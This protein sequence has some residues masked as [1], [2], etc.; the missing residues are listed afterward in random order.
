MGSETGPRHESIAGVPKRHDEVPRFFPSARQSI[1]PAAKFPNAG[2]LHLAF[3]EESAFW[4]VLVVP[5]TWWPR[6]E[7]WHSCDLF[8]RRNI[9]R[10]PLNIRMDPWAGPTVHHVDT[11]I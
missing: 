4:D 9:P 6:E 10:K 2:D 3:L 5:P 7:R 8:G 11:S 1:R